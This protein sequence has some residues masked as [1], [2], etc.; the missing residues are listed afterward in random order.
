MII[1]RRMAEGAAA[2]SLRVG[3]R[4]EHGQKKYDDGA[5]DNEFKTGHA[6]PYSGAGASCG[7]IGRGIDACRRMVN[8]RGGINGRLVKSIMLDDGYRHQ[9]EPDRLLSNPGRA[10]WPC[11]GR[12]MQAVRRSH[13]DRGRAGNAA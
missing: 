1:T 13:R 5:T 4:A 6:N 8:D 9:H 11:Q 3:G 2:S 12:D 10:A 7:A